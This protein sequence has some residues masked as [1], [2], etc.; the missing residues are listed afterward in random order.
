MLVTTT[1]LKLETGSY[2]KGICVV[3]NKHPDEFIHKEIPN[4][5]ILT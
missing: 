1:D 2:V 5:L 4:I 3:Q